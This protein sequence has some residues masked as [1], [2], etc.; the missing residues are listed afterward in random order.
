MMKNRQVEVNLSPRWGEDMHVE[1][2]FGGAAFCVRCL[3]KWIVWQ[4]SWCSHGGV[5]AHHGHRHGRHG[6]ATVATMVCAVAT[7]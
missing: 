3:K 6:V 1:T 7:P 4:Q 5:M 2:I